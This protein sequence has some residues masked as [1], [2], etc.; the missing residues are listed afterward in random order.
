MVER[1]LGKDEVGGSNPLWS[2]RLV[3]GKQSVVSIQACKDALLTS[4][5]SDGYRKKILA[6]IP[7]FFDKSIYFYS[8]FLDVIS[9][10]SERI[11]K[12]DTAIKMVRIVLSYCEKKELLTTEQ[13]LQCRKKLKN[14]KSGVDNHVPTDT[15]IQDTLSKLSVA[16]RL[17]YV[18]YL[19]SGLRKVEGNYLIVNLSKLIAQEKDGFVK[20]TMNYL[21]H[22]KNSFFCYLPSW[23]Y[24]KL[25]I[26]IHQL[27]VSSIEQ[28]IK[29]KKLIP[30]KYCRKWFYTKCIELGVPESIADFYEGR[31]ANSIG[32][33]HYLSKQMLADRYYK[34]KLIEVFNIFINQ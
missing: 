4:N 3:S 19:V 33:N 13:L 20:I 8:E 24:S 25:P 17:V 2:S 28:E 29:R 15:E 18:L 10:N 11:N 9:V 12:D 31:T 32:S 6:K 14:H 27:S 5:L 22:N 23:V 1:V 16:N 21:R 26:I 34:E 7:L 30:I